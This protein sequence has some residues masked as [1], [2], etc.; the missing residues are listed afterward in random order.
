MYRRLLKNS[1]VNCYFATSSLEAENILNS[2]KIDLVVSD[3]RLKQETGLDFIKK[4]RKQE[5]S[6]PMIILSGFAEEEFI[7]QAL[8]LSIVQ[9]FV[10]KPI[11]S[12]D[13]KK[14]LS[15]YLNQELL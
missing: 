4:M 3:Y 1:N 7:K 6:I 13:L 14:V 2:T 8:S 5:I 10:V 15:R 11:S 12:G 9:D